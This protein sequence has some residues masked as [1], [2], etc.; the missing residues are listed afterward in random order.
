MVQPSLRGRD[1][2][3]GHCRRIRRAPVAV[4]GCG[5]PRHGAREPRCGAGLR[6]VVTGHKA[7][8]AGVYNRATYL[9]EKTAA[10]T[11]WAEHLL[12]VAADEPAKVV[13][14]RPATA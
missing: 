7:G 5:L 3:S 4:R 10:L 9:P 13:P 12:A 14:L 6:A 11:R 1:G 8:V 2:H